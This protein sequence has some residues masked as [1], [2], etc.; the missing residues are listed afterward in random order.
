MRIILLVLL[1]LSV[2]NAA[3]KGPFESDV[4][5][6]KQEVL[7]PRFNI[8]NRS[9]KAANKMLTNLEKKVK[10]ISTVLKHSKSS[11]V[12]EFYAIHINTSSMLLSSIALSGI[13]KIAGI[14]DNKI[15][16]RYIVP[17]ANYLYQKKLCDGY[18][19][20]SLTTTRKKEALQYAQEGVKNC[21]YSWKKFELQSRVA[22]LSYLLS[23][24]DD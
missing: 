15:T 20:K 19:F 10:N 14:K 12:K 18:L 5:I 22:K 1:F 16:K 2:T 4:F 21:N 6:F 13:V 9:Y 17:I 11:L 7:E 23:K 24:K 3:G 8:E